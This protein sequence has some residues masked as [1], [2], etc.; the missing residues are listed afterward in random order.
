MNPFQPFYN[1]KIGV[2][3]LSASSA[4][5]IPLVQEQVSRYLGGAAMNSAILKGCQDDALVFG[6][7]PLTG[8]F[9][10]AS[11]LMTASFASPIFKRLCHVPFMLRTGPDM[12]FSGV[13]Y[14]VV[15]GTA[16]EQSIIHVN[17][18]KI[19]ILPAGNLQ[20]MPVPDV[21]RKLEKAFPPFSLSL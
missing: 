8:S 13:D 12:K 9:A 5:V 1:M 21:I 3:D 2:V 16:P 4:D 15:K 18:G 11:S 14:L 17:H 7:G 20:H 10:P 19:R 6:T